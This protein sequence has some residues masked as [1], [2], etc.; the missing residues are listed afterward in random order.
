MAK[1]VE[2]G[3]DIGRNATILIFAVIVGLCFCIFQLRA[4]ASTPE[5]V[6]ALEQCNNAVRI[7]VTFA[8]G[9]Q[10]SSEYNISITTTPEVLASLRHCYDS[11]AK[12]FNVSASLLPELEIPSLKP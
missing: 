6:Q 3:G 5:Y 10:A 4:C 9:N 1:E 7:P 11:V 2:I 12:K 8:N